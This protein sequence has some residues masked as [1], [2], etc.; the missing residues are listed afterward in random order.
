MQIRNKPHTIESLKERT[1]VN[2]CGCW[3]WQGTKRS[4]GYGVTVYKGTQTT[5]HRVMYQIC[6][7]VLLA[8]DIEIDHTCNNRDCIN[9][10][11]LEAVSHAENMSRGAKRRTTCRN[12]HEWND[13][14]TY[15]SEVKRKQ[16]GTRIQ[17]YCRLCRCQHQKDLRTRRKELK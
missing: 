5:T 10:D 6:K 3:I 16:G 15:T 1:V 4:N 13:K 12:G 7:G 11:H 8:K 17:R 9:P 2:D 14:N